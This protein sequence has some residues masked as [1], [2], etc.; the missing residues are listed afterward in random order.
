LTWNIPLKRAICLENVNIIKT[1]FSLLTT[2]NCL[3]WQ[4][5]LPMKKQHAWKTKLLL[6]DIC[7]IPQHSLHVLWFEETTLT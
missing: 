6:F 5:N 4:H 2:E 3:V 7:T 1:C